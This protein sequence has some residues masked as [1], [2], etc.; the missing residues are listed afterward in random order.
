MPQHPQKPNNFEEMI[1]VAEI[2]SEDFPFVRVDLY[3]V[4]G[5]IRFSELT[6]YH[7]AGLVPF[8]PDT[9]DVEF[10]KYF[11]NVMEKTDSGNYKEE[12]TYYD[13]K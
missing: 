2:L 5:E 11:K 6:F 13:T 12:V 3:N 9:F 8:T 1:K 4:N 7:N 10:G